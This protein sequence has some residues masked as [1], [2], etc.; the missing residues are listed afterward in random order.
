MIDH[1]SRFGLRIV[2]VIALAFCAQPGMA[3]VKKIALKEFVA[4]SELIVLATVTKIEDGPPELQPK[5]PYLPPI[6][7]ATA[8]ILETWKGTPVREVRFIASPTWQCDMSH[9]EKGE[10]VVLFLTGEKGSPIMTTHWGRGRMPIREVEGKSYA[11]FYNYGIGLP[12]STPTIPGPESP[13]SP[14]EKELNEELRKEGLGLPPPSYLCVELGK[15]K[16]LVRSPGR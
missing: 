4:G 12:E 1:L 7:V 13:S 15:L 10:K 2:F 5:E 9:A 16:K 11:T 14:S 8:Q 3:D 6:K